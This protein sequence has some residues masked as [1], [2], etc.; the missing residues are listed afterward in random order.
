M[1]AEICK[2][3]SHLQYEGRLGAHARCAKRE[4]DGV[5][6]GVFVKMVN[7]SGNTT[8][9]LDEAKRVV[10]LIAEILGTDWID[11]DRSDSPIPARPIAEA[12]VLVVTPYNHQVR[13]I[14]TELQNAGLKEVRVGTVDKFQGQE[15]PITVVSMAT[16]SSEDLPRG[17]EFLLDP[18]RLNVAISRAQWVSYVIRS[19]QLSIM[20][21]STADG[22]VKLGKFV[23]L[24]KNREPV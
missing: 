14:K 20:E 16:S 1:H 18:H 9:S 19:P 11:V 6:P 17:I 13:M 15:A 5:K 24:C 22:M 3:V 8:N 2:P 4:L 23:S 7:H 12:D 21:P 10:E